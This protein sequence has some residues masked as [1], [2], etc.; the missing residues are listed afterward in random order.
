MRQD[1][2]L[3]PAEYIG[4]VLHQLTQNLRLFVEAE[5]RRIYR[6]QWVD[7]AKQGVLNQRDWFRQDEVWWDS[8]LLLSVMTNH[9]SDV[10][11]TRFEK[12][13]RS[14]IFELLDIRN[15][16]A[17]ERPFKIDDAFRAADSAFRLLEAVSSEG[18]TSIRE[19]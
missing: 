13:Q 5:M 6:E 8:Y 9:W 17:H 19:L 3:T 15:R 11:V 18:A 4:R 1:V 12:G 16:W 10:F 14:L 7:Q 2:R